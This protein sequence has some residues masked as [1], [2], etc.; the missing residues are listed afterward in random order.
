MTHFNVLNDN[1]LQTKLNKWTQN[2]AIV[3]G[4]HYET[5]FHVFITAVINHL[6]A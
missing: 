6:Y 5:L 1:F 4:K 3:M 2:H